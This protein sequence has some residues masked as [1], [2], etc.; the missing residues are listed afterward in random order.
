MKKTDNNVVFLAGKRVNLRP[1]EKEDIPNLERWIN[2][3]EVRRNLTAFLPMNRA[4]EEEWIDS[5]SKRKGMDITLIITVK[6]KPIGTIG[7]HKISLTDRNASLG[8]GIGEKSYWGKGYGTEAITLILRYA[9]NTLNLRKICLSVFAF[10]ERAIACYEKCGFKEEGRL[11]EQRFRDGKY[12]DE[13]RMAVFADK[14]QP[15]KI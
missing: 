15:P 7:F 14:W 10:N 9:F 6:D 12:H 13:V 5:I 11:K 2:D 8:I 1:I 4:D 3:E